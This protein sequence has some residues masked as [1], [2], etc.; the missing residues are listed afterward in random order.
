MSQTIIPQL[1]ITS[2]GS[3]FVFRIDGLQRWASLVSHGL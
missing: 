3:H 2:Q 1:R